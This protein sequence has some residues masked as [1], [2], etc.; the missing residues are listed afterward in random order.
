VK[1]NAGNDGQA[2]AMGGD[3]AGFTGTATASSATS[4]T[5]TGTPFVAS[6]YIGH[7]VVCS[8]AGVLAYGVIT[9]NTTSVLTVDQWY[10]PASPGGAATT[11]PTGTC[12]YVILPGQ[13][14]YWYIAVTTNATAP[15]ATD[16]T[17]TSEITTG[18]SGLI[19]KLA[20]Y[21]HT[22]GVA[23]YSLAVTLTGTATDQGTGAQI[24]AKAGIFNTLTGATGR[25]QFETLIS[26]TATITA[27]GDQV[28]ITDTVT[29]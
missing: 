15:G 28:T 4:L 13:A 14:P 17:L 25:M 24:L 7:I 21:G 11:T 29:N 12:T 23:S 20:T 26:P 6:A 9:A 19:R 8:S 2:Q 10:A 18:G 27:T 3:V 22:L 16:T 1:T 5:A